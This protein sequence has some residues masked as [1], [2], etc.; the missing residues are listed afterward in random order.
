MKM[1]LIEPSKIDKNEFNDFIN[2]FKIAN[3]RLVPYSINQKDMVFQTYI[4]MLTDEALGKGIPEN[5]VP[6]STYFLVDEKQK[7]HGAVNIRHRLTDNLRIEGG[8]IGYGIR[9]SVRKQGYGTKILELAL[10]RIQTLNV[11]KVLVTCDKDNA[12][13]ARIIQKNGGELDSEVKK[14]NK[15]VQRYW[16]KL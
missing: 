6:A 14:D 5:W 1:Q 10:D 12:G 15:I 3:E 7:I 9:P 4:E 13:S 2:E 11:N 16:I 8:H